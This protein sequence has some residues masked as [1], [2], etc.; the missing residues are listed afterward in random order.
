MPSFKAN[1]NGG[2]P[3]I[4]LSFTNSSILVKA[5]L[6]PWDAGVP[7]IQFLF[8]PS[9]LSFESAIGIE[10]NAGARTQ[11]EGQPKPNFS[12]IKADRVTISKIMFD[13]YE[14][15]EN[16]V[17]KYI[18]SLIAAVRFVGSVEG[19]PNAFIGGLPS[20]IQDTVNT[21]LS[22]VSKGISNPI[23]KLTNALS[24]DPKSSEKPNQSPPVY[25]FVWGDQVY[26]RRC[27]LEKLNYKLT[28]FL[29]DGTPVRA[30]IDSLVLREIDEIEQNQD[31]KQAIIDRVKDGLQSR[32]QSSASLRM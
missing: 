21:Q 3:N 9:E 15:G 16:V 31:L 28:M 19:S 10:D 11:K 12:H 1:L 7:K 4:K 2:A 24:R 17:E 25:R 18:K 14:S 32:L 26:L 8:N 20:P 5:I 27:F 13:T 6:V 22:S 30:V 29:P 23:S